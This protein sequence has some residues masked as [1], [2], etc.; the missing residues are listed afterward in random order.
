MPC[1]RPEVTTWH[2]SQCLRHYFFFLLSLL[3]FIFVDRISAT[4]CMSGICVYVVIFSVVCI[5]IDCGCSLI[6]IKHIPFFFLHHFCT[7]H[8]HVLSMFDYEHSLSALS[9][10]F[11]IN[12]QQKHGFLLGELKKLKADIH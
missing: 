4:L 12:P 5:S 8:E 2:C 1:V 10:F 6:C 9:P 7:I 11:K 3:Q